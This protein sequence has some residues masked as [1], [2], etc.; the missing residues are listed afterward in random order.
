MFLRLKGR[1]FSFILCRFFILCKV[2]DLVLSYDVE[3]CVILCW[4][5]QL[6]VVFFF[7]FFFLFVFEKFVRSFRGLNEKNDLGPGFIPYT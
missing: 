3:D 2:S 7:F 4:F 1:S 5:F 6:K